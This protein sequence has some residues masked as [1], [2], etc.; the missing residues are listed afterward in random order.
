M[1]YLIKHNA[2]HEH[3]VNTEQPEKDYLPALQFTAS[4]G[5]T[6]GGCKLPWFKE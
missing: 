2:D 6:F 4:N 1:D 3:Y 5:Y